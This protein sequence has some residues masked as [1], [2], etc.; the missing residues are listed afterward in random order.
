[1]TEISGTMK[2]DSNYMALSESLGFD[3]QE[4]SEHGEHEERDPSG[5]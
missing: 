5:V 2:D 1:M 3:H 4:G